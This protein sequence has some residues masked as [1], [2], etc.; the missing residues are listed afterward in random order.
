[1]Q[2]SP[3][4]HV[5]GS[6][7]V[8]ALLHGT[9][10]VGVS[11]TAVFDRGRDVYSAGWPSY[12]ASDHIL[13]VS[14]QLFCY[15]FLLWDIQYV[16]LFYLLNSERLVCIVDCK[17]YSNYR[18]CQDYR[19]CTTEHVSGHLFGEIREVVRTVIPVQQSMS[20]EIGLVK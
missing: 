18:F 15:A 7:I 12:W 19:S 5:L 2:N 17:S 1:V 13:V 14:K 20:V 16:L 6:S 9:R 4:V 8:A 3:C 10:A 11:Q